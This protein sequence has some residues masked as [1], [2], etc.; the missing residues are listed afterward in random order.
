M[1]TRTYGDLFKLIQSLSGVG[2]FASSEQDDIA[3][4]INRRYSEAFETSPV[5]SRFLITSEERKVLP[6]DLTISGTARADGNPAELNQDY[7]YVGVDTERGMPVYIGKTNPSAAIH[8]D[9]SY[10]WVIG[11]A[12]SNLSI[13]GA[14]PFGTVDVSS[15]STYFRGQLPS[16]SFVANY[17]YNPVSDTYTKI[18]TYTDTVP[19]FTVNKQYIPYSQSN[20]VGSASTQSL[21]TIG[22]FNRI[23]RKQSFNRNSS[24][25]YDFFVDRLG[26][27]I[28][29]AVTSDATS[30]FVTYKQQF[31][32]FTTSSN[33]STS[34]E[35]VPSEFFHYLAHAVYADFLRMDGQTDKSLIEEQNAKNYLDLELERIDLISNN[36][37]IN[38]RFTTY[39]NRQSR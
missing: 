8:R 9:S 38:N 1:Q 12:S 22:G 24:I 20:T 33:Y 4:F 27:H 35:E 32:P 28:L 17:I 14:K 19:T 23:H 13:T 16:T 26:A 31:T 6:L 11:A 30:A 25:E 29:N 34:S 10:R 7:E 2:S 21:S 5:W 36:N 39:V 15:V 37:T 3:N 18:S